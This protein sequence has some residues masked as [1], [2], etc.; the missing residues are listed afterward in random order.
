MGF[1]FQRKSGVLVGVTQG[2]GFFIRN[3]GL[4][5]ATG[6]PR[7]S[8]PEFVTIRDVSFGLTLGRAGRRA[9]A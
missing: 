1:L 6:T 8:A 9:A 5:P 4:D 3:I 7:W 2:D